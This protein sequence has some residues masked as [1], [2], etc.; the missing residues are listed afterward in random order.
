MESCNTKGITS[1]DGGV[2]QRWLLIAASILVKRNMFYFN[3]LKKQS[4]TTKHRT[5]I[6]NWMTN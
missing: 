6:T 1:A 3:P 2:A 5:N 4:I